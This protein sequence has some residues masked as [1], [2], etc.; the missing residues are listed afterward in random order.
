[1]DQ[2]LLLTW[3]DLALLM[4]L[5]VSVV[6]GA[7][8]GFVYEALSLAAWVVAY[9]ASPFLA[10]WVQG[11]LPAD[12]REA[13]WQGVASVVLAFVLILVLVSLVAKLL[14]ALLHATPL[15]AVDRLL[16]CGF[17]LLRGVLLC[18][19][20]G[21]LVGMTPLRQH[22]TWTQSHARPV[23]VGVLR[24]LAP[25]LPGGLHQWLERP[26]LSSSPPIA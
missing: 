7:I 14:R 13:G 19:L 6:V 11:W 26:L 15:K 18:L 9:F 20:A 25:L 1:M 2:E 21:V 16:G 4:V 5:G 3:V 8:R 24:S 22:P 12:S 23:L 10:P 17:G